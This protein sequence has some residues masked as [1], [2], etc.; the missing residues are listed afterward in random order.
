MPTRDVA[1]LIGSLRK[2]SW[3]RIAAQAAAAEAPAHLKFRFIDI[4]VSLYN[5]DLDT[6]RPPEDWQRLRDDIA[7]ADAVLFATPEYNRSVPGVLKNAIDIASRPYGKG[8]LLRKPAA[9]MSTSVGAIG[10]FGANHHLRQAAAYLDMPMLGQP[11]IYLGPAEQLFE[12]GGAVKQTSTRELL[13]KFMAAFAA[14]IEIA[15]ERS[16]A[17]EAGRGR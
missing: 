7:P 9:I 14:W 11:E 17:R 4:A 1:V 15:A 16:P 2:G 13:A 12:A 5:Q 10:G 8:V 3:N 6:D